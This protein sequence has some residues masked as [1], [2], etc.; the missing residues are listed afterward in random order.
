MNSLKSTTKIRRKVLNRLQSN[1]SLCN[2]QFAITYENSVTDTYLGKKHLIS[3]S[4]YLLSP[5]GILDFE[6]NFVSDSKHILYLQVLFAFNRFAMYLCNN[7]LKKVKRLESS[8]KWCTSEYFITARI[9]STQTRNKR[10]S[11]T[12]RWGI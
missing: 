1:F 3:L 4:V 11:S 2:W 6:G 10:S 5:G 12:E 7:W 8:A 9:S